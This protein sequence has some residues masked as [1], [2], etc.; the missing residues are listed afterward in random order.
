VPPFILEKNLLASPFPWIAAGKQGEKKQSA[1]QGGH[2]CATMRFALRPPSA[3]NEKE[4]DRT[5][6]ARD[7]RWRGAL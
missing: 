5:A 7:A 2:A 1:E 3:R 6:Q 4:K